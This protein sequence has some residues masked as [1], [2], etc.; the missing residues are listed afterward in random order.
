[1]LAS[2]PA[3]F[4]A[5]G[6]ETGAAAAA[7]RPRSHACDLRICATSNDAASLIGSLVRPGDVVLVKGSRGIATERIV[8][9]LAKT[10]G[11]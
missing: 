2:N 6:E 5:I 1:V 9:A 8:E 3:V 10:F 4:V 11:A 7:A